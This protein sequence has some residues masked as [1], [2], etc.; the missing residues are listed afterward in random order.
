L[1]PINVTLDEK[2]YGTYDKM[3]ERFPSDI[4][5]LLHCKSLRIE[6]NVCFGESITIRG[7]VTIS[8]KS[9]T[10]AVITDGTVIERDIVF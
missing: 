1:P 9:S 6:G 3:K 4:P 10:Q 8:N 2:Y 7:D 5:S